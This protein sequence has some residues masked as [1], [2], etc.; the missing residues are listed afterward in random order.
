[1]RK[2]LRHGGLANALR[3]EDRFE[4]PGLFEPVVSDAGLDA[5]E[6]RGCVHPGWHW[7]CATGSRR[8][9]GISIVGRTSQIGGEPRTGSACQSE[10]TACV[11]L[12]LD[13]RNERLPNNSL[14][15]QCAHDNHQTDDPHRDTIA[16]TVKGPTKS[17]FAKKIL[18]RVLVARL[19][20]LSPHTIRVPAPRG[21]NNG[22]FGGD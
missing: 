13:P 19:S 12:A 9:A 8:A 20:P 5:I 3:I 21:I 15:A 2:V 6:F 16:H 11:A 10:H 22:S 17:S 4:F 7:R 14:D 1:M 18:P